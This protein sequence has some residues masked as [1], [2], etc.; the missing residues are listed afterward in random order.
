MYNNTQILTKATAQLTYKA[1][2]TITCDCT[3]EELHSILNAPSTKITLVDSRA[4]TRSPLHSDVPMTTVYQLQNYS[5]SSNSENTI[6][7]VVLNFGTIKVNVD[8]I[9]NTFAIAK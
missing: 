1:D 7:D 4:T 5:I 6:L 9:N 3:G 2:H 8:C